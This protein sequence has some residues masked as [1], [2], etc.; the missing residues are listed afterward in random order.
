VKKVSWLVFAILFSIQFFAHS[1]EESYSGL[2]LYD[3]DLG[4]VVITS[5]K[6]EQKYKYSTQN[7]SIVTAKELSVSGVTEISEILDL[8][9]SVDIL[10]YG[11]S[12]SV[13]SVHTRGA[14][15]N[16]VLTLI[17]GRPINAPRDGVTDFNRISLSNIE[18]IEV[19]RGPAS[20]IYGANAVGGVINIITKEGTDEMKTEVS[21]RFGS[22]ATKLVSITHGYKVNNFDYFIAY[23]YLAS[24]GHRDNSD[25]LSHNVNT[26]LGFQINDDNRISV[27]SGYYNSEA[28]SPGQVF[29][30]DLDDRQEVFNKYVDLTYNGKFFEGQ[31][32]LLKVYH[33]SDRLEFVE[34]Y[35]PI[36][37]DTHHTKVYGFESQLS[38]T[39]FDIFRTAI[40]FDHKISRLN[41]STS[42]KHSYHTN[43]AYIE[44]EIDVLDV[45]DFFLSDGVFKASV[46]W[47][48]YSNFGD[49]LSPSTS[50][51]VWLFDTVKLHALVAKSFRAP[52]FNDLYWPREDWGIFGG[53]E[54]DS[55]LL[56][57]EAT[58]Y[59]AGFSTYLFDKFKTDVTLFKTKFEDL[60]EWTVDS[61][62]WWRP[63]NVNSAVIKG[64]ELETEFVIKDSLK[65]NFN[66][67]Y[68]EA[69]DTVTK[70][71]L[72]YRPRHLYKL[73]LRYS[74]SQR[75]EFGLQFIYKTKRFANSGN[76][77][78]LGSDYFVNINGTYKLTDNVSVLLEIKNIF[79]RD[80]EEERGYSLPG[81]AFYG[82]IKISF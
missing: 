58:S 40:G 4:K 24:A 41:S 25:Y 70:K 80:Y 77:V 61:S 69:K 66:Y 62:W 71:W 54:G 17:D 21:T 64:V 49:R 7:I 67:T 46:R 78:L 2:G 32:L 47:D 6:L 12:G 1:Q 11:S 30:Q 3:I 33:N 36:D 53:V 60:I 79:N 37:K 23:D 72:I 19:L 31:D 34:A 26:K 16:Q 48:D 51:N 63:T 82:G 56:P 22:F 50:F 75:A 8:L 13:R 59:E 29:F 65:A 74:P 39:F 27:T 18:R 35:N 15:S 5:S 43:G 52:T 14:S 81:R 55:S 44:S 68:L 76:T 10:E 42:A 20:N 28:G 45:E 73:H 9:P 38:H 57:E